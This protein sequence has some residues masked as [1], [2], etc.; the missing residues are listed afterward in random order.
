MFPCSD[1][2]YF[3]RWTVQIL[4]GVFLFRAACVWLSFLGRSQ[5]RVFL[6]SLCIARARPCREHGCPG[7]PSCPGT[8][9]GIRLQNDNKRFPKAQLFPNRLCFLGRASGQYSGCYVFVCG[10]FGQPSVCNGQSGARCAAHSSHRAIRWRFSP[11]RGFM[12]SVHTADSLPCY[13]C[14]FFAFIASFSNFGF[15]PAAV[16]PI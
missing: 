3:C 10:G 7:N 11:A 1:Y 4:F 12:P 14:D 16:Y 9:H 15:S 13:L 5:R 8:M 2:D 6:G